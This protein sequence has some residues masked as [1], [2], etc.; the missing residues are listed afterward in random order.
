MLA[1]TPYFV[2][3]FGPYSEGCFLEN[4]LLSIQNLLKII[5]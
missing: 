2:L 3:A 5:L 1:K 4:K